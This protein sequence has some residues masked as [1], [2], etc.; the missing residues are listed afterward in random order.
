MGYLIGEIWL[1]LAIAYT[2]GLAAGWLIW[3][4][5]RRKTQSRIDDLER[6]VSA[7]KAEALESEAERSE[8]AAAAVAAEAEI[9]RLNAR[10]SEL[11]EDSDG[12]SG[13]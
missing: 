1:W 5:H 4:L 10:I 13:N 8:L 9:A 2:I 6:Q 7:A 3:R 11:M 12:E